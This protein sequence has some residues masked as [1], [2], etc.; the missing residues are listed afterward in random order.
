MET[1]EEQNEVAKK[2]LRRA[3][4]TIALAG[5]AKEQR[6]RSVIARAAVLL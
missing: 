4:E 2:H 6:P 5:R 3:V 1:K